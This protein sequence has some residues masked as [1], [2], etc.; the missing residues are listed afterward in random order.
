MKT[1]Q[2]KVKTLTSELNGLGGFIAVCVAKAPVGVSQAGTATTGPGYLFGLPQTAGTA[3]AATATT[4]LDLA[5]SQPPQF[6]FYALNTSDPDCVTIVNQLAS[7][8]PG[9]LP[10]LA[11]QR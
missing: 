4:A 2:G 11:P 7:H 3:V 9:Y 8:G 5:G 10:R 6:R 1:V